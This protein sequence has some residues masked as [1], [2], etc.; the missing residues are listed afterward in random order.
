MSYAAESNLKQVWLECGG[1]S[2]NLVFADCDDLAAAAD[3][4]VSGESS[5]NQGQV[6]LGELAALVDRG[7]KEEFLSMVL[8]AL[9]HPPR[10]IPWTGRRMGAWPVSP[11]PSA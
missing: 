1:K 2:A 8:D 6:V 11:T 5:S 4:S 9:P 3:R 7:I 10:P